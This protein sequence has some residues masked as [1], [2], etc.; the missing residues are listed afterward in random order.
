ME[1]V[2]EELIA[3]INAAGVNDVI[4]VGHSQGGQA[5]SLM[6]EMQ[7]ALF[8]RLIYVSC[9]IPKPG[10]TVLQMIGNSVCGTNPDGV[11]WPVDPGTTTM[12]QLYELMFCNDMTESQAKGFLAELGPDQWPTATYCYTDWRNGH[13]DTIPSSYVRCLR[14]NILPLAWQDI[15]AERFKAERTVTVDAGH[16]A[17]NTPPHALAEALLREARGEAVVGA[18]KFS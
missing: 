16:Q 8:R 17:M 11:G 6:A 1:L 9:S 4:L 7:P 10:Q 5:M 13:L 3:D 12:D 14:D 15:F 2:A 18:P